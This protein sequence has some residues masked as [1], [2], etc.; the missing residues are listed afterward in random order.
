MSA[1]REYMSTLRRFST[2]ARLYLLASILQGIGFGIFQLFFNFYIL[3]LGYRRDFL[4]LLISLPSIT[5]LGVALFTGYVSD[6]IG[7]KRAFIGSRLLAA[8]AQGLMLIWP[9]PAGLILSGIL[10]GI[11]ESLFRATSAPFL[12]EESGERERTHLFSFSAG[13]GTLSSFLGS[14][15]GGYLPTLFA[16]YLGFDPTSSRAYAWVLGVAMLLSLAALIPFSRLEMH[17]PTQNHASPLEPFRLLWRRRGPLGKLLIPQLITSLG[18]GMLVPFLNLFFRDR[19]ALSD[20]LIGVLF[21]IGALGMGIATF[22]A[23]P[24]AKRLGKVQTVVISRTLSILPLIVLGYVHHL[25][26]A[27]A[28]FLLRMML[29]NLALPVYRMLVVEASDESTRGMAS[30]LYNIVWHSGRAVTPS[31]SGSIQER[32]GF[33]PIFAMSIASYGMGV[34]LLYRWLIRPL[35]QRARETAVAS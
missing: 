32:Y 3:S 25:H 24:I 7:R 8:A 5:T 23:P 19:Y 14:T 15:L 34:F 35:Q 11:G 20:H 30:S 17:K 16:L 13:L 21:G 10:Q 6:R 26:L 28:A 27:M 29:M 31:I 4:G 9:V 22:L 12:L 2:G 1:L 18:A 33:D